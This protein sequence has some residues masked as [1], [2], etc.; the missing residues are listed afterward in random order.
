[1]AHIPVLLEEVIQY[2]DPKPNENF[3]DATIGNGGHT[4]EILDKIKPHGKVLGIDW[5]ENTI[6]KLTKK[7]KPEIEAK[8]LSLICDNFANLG[9]IVESVQFL[10]IAGMLFDLGMSSEELE[11]S[12]LG[13][14]FQK[15]EP[16]VMTYSEN[17]GRQG[18]TAG[19]VVNN[20]DEHQLAKIFSE[21]GQERFAARASRAI[22]ARRKIRKIETSKQLAELM[23]EAMPK[24]YE[25]GRI[26]PATRIFQALRIYVND[27]LGNLEKGLVA[28]FENT[29]T[30][31]RIVV[32]AYHSLED[33]IVK[34]TFR[35]LVSAGK[36]KLLT[37]KPVLAGSEERLRNPRS[38]S[39]KLRAI[40]KT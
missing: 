20:F 37:A 34:R 4:Q 15:D 23:L 19:E 5:N 29:Q 30:G 35:D 36:G 2:L 18:L 13:F 32:I 16:L 6:M 9:R 33:R 7:F 40:K 39:A 25:R 24:N 22:T 8:R 3:I 26:H 11:E 21:F 38:R 27:E 1:M 12:G 14:S 31:G 10:G 17:Q 28:G